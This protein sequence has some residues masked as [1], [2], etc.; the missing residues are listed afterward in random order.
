MKWDYAWI[1][2][3]SANTRGSVCRRI[4]S[5]PRLARRSSGSSSSVSSCRRV[6]LTSS[7]LGEGAS[8]ERIG[9]VLTILQLVALTYVAS[10]RRF[11]KNP[12]WTNSTNMW[13][14]HHALAYM[15]QSTATYSEQASISKWKDMKVSSA[16]RRASAAKQ[17]SSPEPR[18]P[19]H[20]CL[21]FC[22]T[23]TT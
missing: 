22:C 12:W 11:E 2:E 15:L 20:S 5:F 16:T 9:E 17:S 14:P 18:L 10:L 19:L 7:A 3:A 13:I 4:V 8:G 1:K 6:L 23:A 21:S